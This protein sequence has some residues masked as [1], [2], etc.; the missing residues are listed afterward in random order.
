MQMYFMK[1]MWIILKISGYWFFSQ[2]NMTFQMFAVLR[3]KL[4]KFLTC[5][6]LSGSEFLKNTKY[7][8]FCIDIFE[9]FEVSCSRFYWCF[10]IDDIISLI[11]WLLIDCGLVNSEIKYTIFEISFF[12]FLWQIDR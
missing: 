11:G 1:F 2:F 4:I 3:K 9:L 8:W 5:N 12:I 7:D 6:R 10:Y